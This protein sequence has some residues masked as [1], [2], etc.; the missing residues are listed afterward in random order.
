MNNL[1]LENYLE[2]INNEKQK[3]NLGDFTP[4]YPMLRIENNKLY[5]GVMLTHKNANVWDKN[6]S[7]KPE[8]WVL[9]DLNSN[10]ILEWNET[11]KKDFVIDKL[12]EKN[13]SSKQEEISKYEIRKRLEYKEYLMNDIKKDNLPIQQKLLAILNDKIEIDGEKVNLNDYLFANMETEITDKVNELV[14]LMV[15]SKYN[16]LTLYY[17]YLF[18]EIVNVYKNKN[19]IDREKMELC[20]EIMDNYYDGIIGIANFFNLS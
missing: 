13:N 14:N 11:K 18:K 17:D 15:I 3:R 20:F 6:V 7:I 1:K 19:K 2:I 12:I 9:L 5:V 8:Y 4:L 16:S 10:K